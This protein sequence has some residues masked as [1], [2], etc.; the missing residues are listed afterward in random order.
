MFK[1]EDKELMLRAVTGWPVATEWF[2]AYICPSCLSLVPDDDKW[3]CSECGKSFALLVDLPLEGHCRYIFSDGKCSYETKADVT[4][5]RIE[6]EGGKCVKTPLQRHSLD[7][8]LGK[9]KISTERLWEIINLERSK[10]K[11][12][13]SES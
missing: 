12:S 3:E 13:P 9:Y 11:P 7:A 10:N 8:F 2:S 6:G 5:T 4:L 1:D